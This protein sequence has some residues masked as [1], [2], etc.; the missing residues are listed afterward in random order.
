VDPKVYT[1][2]MHDV[3]HIHKELAS[4]STVI[5]Y[6]INQKLSADLKENSPFLLDT[7]I[8]LMILVEGYN[9]LSIIRA[10]VH[11]LTKVAR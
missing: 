10:H 4:A 6:E 9:L 7:F 11:L 3:N 8:N 1:P 2:K 5:P